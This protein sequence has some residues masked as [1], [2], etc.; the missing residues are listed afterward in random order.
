MAM[1]VITRGYLICHELSLGMNQ[2]IFHLNIWNAL[3]IHK[4]EFPHMWKWPIEIDGLPINSMV[5]FHG[6]VN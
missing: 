3:D 6:Y 2:R 1:L 5:I 4:F